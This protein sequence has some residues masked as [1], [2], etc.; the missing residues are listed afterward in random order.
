M[1]Q[2]PFTNRLFEGD[3]PEFRSFQIEIVNARPD[4]SLVKSEAESLDCP[5]VN[6]LIKCN[7]SHWI[8]IENDIIT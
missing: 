6:R 4:D 1:D 8:L 7:I 2:G 3:K 5:P